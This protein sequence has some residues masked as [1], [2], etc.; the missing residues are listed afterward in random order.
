MENVL[1]KTK[2]DSSELKKLRR[3]AQ[4]LAYDLRWQFLFL[5][6]G[7]G[8]DREAPFYPGD[9]NDSQIEI[10][11]EIEIP[12]EPLVLEVLTRPRTTPLEIRWLYRASVHLRMSPL[13]HVLYEHPE[14][15][16]AAKESERYAG[17]ATRPSSAKRR[18]DYL[19]KVLAGLSLELRATT[20]ERRL[21]DLY[22]EAGIAK[23]STYGRV[24]IVVAQTVWA[25]WTRAR[26]LSRLTSEELADGCPQ[27]GVLYRHEK[28]HTC[29]DEWHRSDRVGTFIGPE[30]C[31]YCGFHHY[32]KDCVSRKKP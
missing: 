25:R 1:S 2:Y 26:D 9:G 8:R 28:F 5:W 22:R 17:S 20:G 6:I 31:E 27:C 10:P 11:P 12:A 7:E 3:D 13:G 19:T 4:L 15:F 24:H 23:H 29:S 30:F 32:G 16:C 14:E 18:V 21:R